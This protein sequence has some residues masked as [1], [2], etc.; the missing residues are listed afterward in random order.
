MPRQSKPQIGRRHAMQHEKPIAVRMIEISVRIL[1]YTD[2]GVNLMH[3]D[4]GPVWVPR[5][6]CE[7]EGELSLDT[8]RLRL[9]EWLARDRKLL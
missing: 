6:Q 5:S 7:C 9:P 4:K 3:N 1:A 2:R 8:Q